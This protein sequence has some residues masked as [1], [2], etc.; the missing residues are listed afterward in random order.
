M[1][2][3]FHIVHNLNTVRCYFGD[4]IT[5]F[6]SLSYTITQRS[7]EFLNLPL[8][9]NSA[10]CLQ[11]L[12]LQ[13]TS[14]IITF[15][16]EGN[17]SKALEYYDLQIRSDPVAQGSSYSPNNLLH[18]SGSEVDKMTEKKPYKGLIRS[19]QQIG[20]THLLDVYCQGLTSQKGR[21]QHDPEFTE[22]QVC[23]I[24]FL[25]SVTK[26]TWTQFLE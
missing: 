14:Q 15:E 21:F 17:W 22:L 2:F 18:S 1:I 11:F 16:H 7:V 12:S 20:C 13:L 24:F 26:R 4:S 8:V 25:F 6:Y 10:H 9:T 5:Y 19:L 23:L 3:F